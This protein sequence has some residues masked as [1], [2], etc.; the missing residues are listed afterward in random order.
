MKQLRA[1]IH[2]KVVSTWPIPEKVE[3]I[4]YRQKIMFAFAYDQFLERKDDLAPPDLMREYANVIRAFFD[5]DTAE[6]MKMP[7]N[8]MDDF[9]KSMT[10]LFLY[11]F[12]LI[13]TYVPKLRKGDQDFEFEYKGEKWII[14]YALKAK[15]A[16][17]T[18]AQAIELL[19][20][21][22]KANADAKARVDLDNIVFSAN[23]RKFVCL[24]KKE[25]EVL[26]TDEVAL[27][28]LIEERIHH[29][30]QVDMVTMEDALF[31]LTHGKR[32][33]SGIRNYSGSG[34]LPNDPRRI[35]KRLRDTIRGAMQAN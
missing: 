34:I 8:L 25:N 17:I 1:K 3:E 18:F 2:G 33:F 27:R 6:V 7:V 35:V 22:R 10:G 19:E 23:L 24:V 20:I 4:T 30:M 13:H 32:T 21:E 14:P 5:V 11:L 16:E 31:F 15:D 26:P 28:N 29:F 12:G 9:E